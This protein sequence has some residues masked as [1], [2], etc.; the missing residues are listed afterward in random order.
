MPKLESQAAKPAD[1]QASEPASQP[2][3]GVILHPPCAEPTAAVEQADT[4]DQR[5]A[6]PTADEIWRAALRPE[7]RPVAERHGRALFCFAASLGILNG[8][9]GKLASAGQHTVSKLQSLHQRQAANAVNAALRTAH[10]Q[11]TQGANGVIELA[12]LGNGWTQA[13][14]VE[15]QRDINRAAELGRT[16]TSNIILA[17]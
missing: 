10:A 9:L 11:I 7:M 1:L 4:T 17:H 8:G 5:S 14:I 16:D 13:Q 15:C 3:A 12:V 2:L 6:A